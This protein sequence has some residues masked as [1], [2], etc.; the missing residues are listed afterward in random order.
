MVPMGR[1]VFVLGGAR[2]G[3]TSYALNIGEGIPA[4]QRWYIATSVVC[5]E[6]MKKKVELH[7][8][9]RGERWKSLEAPYKLEDAI[10]QVG[11]RDVVVLVDCLTMWINNLMFA[12]E[13]D[14]AIQERFDGLLSVLSTSK[15]TV[16]VVSN[17]VGLGIVPMDASARRFRELVGYLNQGVARMAHEV[18]FLVAGIPLKLKG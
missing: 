9:E 5:D 1:I 14:R 6:E 2:S 11:D 18:F 7:K 10:S 15:G 3:K 8:R 17:E 16:I 4:L 13:S 12:G